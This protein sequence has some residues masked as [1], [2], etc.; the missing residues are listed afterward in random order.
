[1]NFGCFLLARA[2]ASAYGWDRKCKYMSHVRE[3]WP[4]APRA[5]GSQSQSWTM[6]WRLVHLIPLLSWP[7]EVLQSAALAVDPWSICPASHARMKLTC[8]RDLSNIRHMLATSH[9]NHS[10]ACLCQPFW[11]TLAW[12][13]I[14]P[15]PFLNASCC[16]VRCKNGVRDICHA[17]VQH[18]LVIRR[19]AI[20]RTGWKVAALDISTLDVQKGG[21]SGDRSQVSY[22]NALMSSSSKFKG[23]CIYMTRPLWHKW[24]SCHV[25]WR[26]GILAREHCRRMSAKGQ[27]LLLAVAAEYCLNM[28]EWRRQIIWASNQISHL[29]MCCFHLFSVVRTQAG[30]NR[31]FCCSPRTNN[32]NEERYLYFDGIKLSWKKVDE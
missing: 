27:K 8:F 22:D 18:D 9:K 3:K 5:L 28:F 21:G 30:P 31:G 23:V 6:A 19:I 10:D 26:A 14:V 32:T 7:N 2:K 13:Q 1:M 25:E 4:E 15:Q 17:W 11:Q 12:C 29:W 20:R 16:A 24:H